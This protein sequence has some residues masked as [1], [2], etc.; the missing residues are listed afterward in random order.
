M[1]SRTVLLLGLTSF[2]TDISSEMVATV[3]P[4]YLVLFLQLSPLQF[5]VLDGIYQGGAALV[6][7]VGGVAADRWR[8][9]KEVAAFGYALSAVSK[10]GLLVAGAA[11]TPIS[12]AI[13]LDRIGKGI[14]TGPRDALIAASTPPSELG[15][16][17]GVHRALDTAGA[18]L[19]PLMAFGILAMAPNAYDLVFVVS[20]CVA[21][22]GVGVIGLLVDNRTA[23]G[24]GPV[25]APPESEASSLR[26]SLELLRGGPFRRLVF[27]GG[28]LGLVTI[29]DA[30]VYLML[31]RRSGLSPAYVPLLFVGTALLYMLLAVPMGRLAD[32]IGRTAVFV[33]GY[34]LLLG[35]YAAVLAGG[36]GLVAVGVCVGLLGVYYAATDGV[37][38]ALAS[39]LLPEGLRASGLSVLATVT[40]LTRLAASVLFGALWSWVGLEAAVAAFA[41]GLV[42]ALALAFLSIAGSRAA[43]A[44]A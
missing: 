31:Q 28:V 43:P 1:V 44:R 18:M 8:R 34:A 38:A 16:A 24:S 23:A 32:R 6:R 15:R 36:V 37:L 39:G 22:V 29:S 30:F 41:V 13:V 40:N 17:F 14:R 2:L 4:V 27:A 21:V 10:L 33:G 25:A 12:T 7:V 3:L 26:R 11:W 19:G 35:V 42:V 9:H 20:L 5:G